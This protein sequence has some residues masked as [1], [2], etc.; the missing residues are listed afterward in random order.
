MH[1][2]PRLDEARKF[3]VG[4]RQPDSPLKSYQLMCATDLA[5]ALRAKNLQAGAHPAMA[6]PGKVLLPQVAEGTQ[7]CPA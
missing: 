2:L 4:V 5:K 7:N 3:A 1:W 6:V